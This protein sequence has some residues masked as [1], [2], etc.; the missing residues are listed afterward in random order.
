MKLT[1]KR[2]LEKVENIAYLDYSIFSLDD[3]LVGA[4]QST[5]I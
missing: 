5:H 2:S 4:L 3:P 1:Q